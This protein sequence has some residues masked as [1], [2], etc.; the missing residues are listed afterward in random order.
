[1]SNIQEFAELKAVKIFKPGVHN[2]RKFTEDHLEQMA[3]NTNECLDYVKKSILQGFYEKNKHIR[4]KGKPIPSLINL[5]HQEDLRDTIKDATKNLGIR[6]Y[7][8]VI[9]GIKWLLADY[10]NVPNDVAKFLKKKYPFRSVEILPPMY[11]P[12]KKAVF[13]WVVRSVGF[14][15]ST[16]VP[17]V[18]GQSNDFVVNYT[19]ENI[20]VIQTFVFDMEAED[21]EETFMAEDTKK[22]PDKAPVKSKGQ[23]V[24]VTEFQE[25]KDKIE[26]QE[27]QINTQENQIQEYKGLLDTEKAERE[28]LRLMMLKQTHE[29]EEKDINFYCDE[30]IKHYQ[31]KPVLLS[32]SVR[33]EFLKLDDQETSEFSE[34][35]EKVQKTQRQFWWDYVAAL[36]TNDTHRVPIGEYAASEA[37]QE[38]LNEDEM[39]LKLIG[40]YT[41]KTDNSLSEQERFLVA[42]EKAMKDGRW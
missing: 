13:P 18:K 31:I 17:A 27:E 35:G 25:L 37:M 20:N 40:E 3:H 19:D 8:K 34:K 26:A 12:I 15:D 21:E 28:A 6:L 41:E 29:Q 36:L 7:T 22:A 5:N 38:S 14:L 24:S 1:M 42:Y 16:T 30:L 23:E 4:L 9:N 33:Q 10:T 32:E 39:H 2:G 11:H